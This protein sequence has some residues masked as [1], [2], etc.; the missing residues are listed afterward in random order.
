MALTYF[1]SARC[2]GSGGGLRPTPGPGSGGDSGACY[3]RPGEK[4]S[5]FGT[6]HKKLLNMMFSIVEQHTMSVFAAEKVE[7]V[8][9]KSIFVNQRGK[10]KT[11]GLLHQES[12][13]KN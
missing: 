10:R 1:S 11:S 3:K 7:Q 4:S 6:D 5:Q 12:F 2:G 9:E 13:D 8:G